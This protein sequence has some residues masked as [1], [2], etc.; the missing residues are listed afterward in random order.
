VKYDLLDTYIFNT[1]FSNNLSL[2][3]SFNVRGHVLQSH[4][5]KINMQTYS[6]IAL[7]IL[8]LVG[9]V[10]YYLFIYLFSLA[11]QPSVG[12]GLLVHEVS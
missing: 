8:L 12:S 4:T 9:N 1:L 3:F 6:Y 2:Y 10:Y 7:Y 5:L 11:L